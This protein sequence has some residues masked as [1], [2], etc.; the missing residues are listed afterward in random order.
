MRAEA[1]ATIFSRSSAPPPPLIRVRSGRDLVGAV[2]GQVEL[3]R[4]VER[5]QR[6]AE[7]LG[8]GARRLRGRHADDVEAG[9]HP[10]GQQL[11]EMLG[12]RAGAE[13]EPHARPHP[14]DRQRRGLTFLRFDVHE[15]P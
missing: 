13:A 14:F 1:A 15:R 10:L 12:G 6:H 5:G 7:P 11:D 9:A 8:L 2:D 3:G 4:L